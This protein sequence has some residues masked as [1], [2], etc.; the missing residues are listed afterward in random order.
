[1][2]CSVFC[3]RN[4]FFRRWQYIILIAAVLIILIVVM[5]FVLK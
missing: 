5:V 3:Q 2:P 1:V 4:S